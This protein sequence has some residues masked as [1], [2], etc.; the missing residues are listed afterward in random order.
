MLRVLTYNILLGGSQRL[1]ELC[2]IIQASDADIIG[3]VEATNPYVV[4]EL[5]RRLDMHY[6]LTGHARSSRDWQIALLSRLPIIRTHDHMRPDIFGRRHFLEVEVEEADGSRLTIFV[7]HLTSSFF[8]GQSSNRQRRREVEEMLR[9]LSSCHGKPH[10]VMGDFNSL[11]DGEEFRLSALL[12]HLRFARRQKP[13][14]FKHA[15]SLL[16]Y[17]LLQLTV[18]ARFSPLADRVSRIFVQGGIDQ[19][20][21]AGYVDCFRRLHPGEAGFTYHSEIPACRIDYIFASSEMASR[22]TSSEVILKGSNG[23][24]SS[25]ASDHMPLRAD[26]R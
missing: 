9:I 7:I 24:L 3:L 5:A 21:K 1:E 10:L 19:I 6:Y 2:A 14:H 23:Y 20:N 17:W 16:K 15:R 11:T 12:R 8:R 25:D 18:N 22:L 26:F 13:P 4:E